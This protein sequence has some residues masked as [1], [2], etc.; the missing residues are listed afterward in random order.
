MHAMRF[1]RDDSQQQHVFVM[2]AIYVPY[3]ASGMYDRHT[4]IS[5]PCNIITS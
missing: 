5:R 1:V 2:Y 3:R 4:R